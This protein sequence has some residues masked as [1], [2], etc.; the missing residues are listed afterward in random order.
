MTLRDDFIF[1]MQVEKMEVTSEKIFSYNWYMH[2]WNL[3][4]SSYMLKF[5]EVVFSTLRSYVYVMGCAA[6]MF[7]TLS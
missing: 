7:L 3:K 5:E 1:E 6:V 4:R 2:V